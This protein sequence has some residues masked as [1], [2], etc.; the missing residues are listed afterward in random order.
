MAN[1]FNL[2]IS[3]SMNHSPGILCSVVIPM[4]GLS[5]I[6]TVGLC[7]GGAFESK[8]TLYGRLQTFLVVTAV[9]RM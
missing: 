1:F 4:I 6:Y 9:I 3:M 7:M 2:F 8:S 5:A